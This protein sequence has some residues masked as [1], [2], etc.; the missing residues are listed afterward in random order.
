ML[1]KDVIG[2]PEGSN[3]TIMNVFYTRPIRNE[4]TGKYDKDYLVI[5]FKN[6]DTGKKEIRIDVEPEYTWYLLKKEYQTEH[7]LAFIE[8]DK[9]EPITCKY[10]DIKL[11]IAK[12]TGNE[13]L[14][15]QNMYSGNFRLNDAFFAHPRSFAADMNILNYTRSRFAE[16]YKNPVIP[17]DIFFFDIESDIID[18]ISDNVTIGECPVNA[19]TGYYSKTNTL[20]NFV[21]RNKRNKQIQELEDDMKKDFKKY[22]EKVRSFIEYDLGS[23][24]KVIKYKLDNVELSVGFFDDELSLILE[25]FKLV[26]SLSPDIVTAYNIS[27]DLPSLIERLKANG[28]DPRDVI[29]DQD[30]PPQYR[31]CE[32]ILDEKNLNNIE[33][34][35]DFANISARSTY[36]DQ[37]ITYASRR[38][39]Q[40]AIESNKLDYVG[41]LECGVRKLDYHEITT[42]I[43]KL[44]Y[45]NFYIF[46][47]YNIIDVVVQVCIEAQTDD[48]KYVFNNVIEMN[49]PFQKIFRQTNYL[50]TKAVEFY[51]HH[52]GVII[53]NNI[54][55]FGK[56]PEEK[57]SGAFVADPTKISDKNKV[58]INGQ[59][60]YKYNNGNDFDYKRLYPSLM[61]EFNMATNTQVGKIFID[62][63]PYKDPEYLKLSPGGTFTENLASYNYIEFCHRWLGMMDVE[64]ILQE[65]PKMNLSSDKK[66]VIDLINPNKIISIDIPMPN[67]VKDEVDKI[68]KELL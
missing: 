21:L 51:K 50:G 10:K 9:V 32:Y 11:S 12:E 58:R 24:E 40:S 63:P 30:I 14:Y 13:D 19:I 67:W 41:T 53:G 60:I 65:I 66:Q 25:F 61:Q 49:T 17:I 45:L 55:R 8:K 37:M 48:L 15:K 4:E 39:G 29:C 43:G 54:N 27:Y 38:K 59:P 35:G 64:E 44:P 56:K 16:I 20:Y 42:D 3:L 47:L 22:K 5:I 57:F 36:L 31:F 62:N 46:W 23:K 18:S 7:N 52:E 28:A 2:Y 1:L 33:E 68:R 34:R 6:N 26:H